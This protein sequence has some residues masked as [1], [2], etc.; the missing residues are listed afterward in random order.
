MRGTRDAILVGEYHA[1]TDSLLVVN[2][3]QISHLNSI[4]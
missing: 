1:V 2:N 4:C 3:I